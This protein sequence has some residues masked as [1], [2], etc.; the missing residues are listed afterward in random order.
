MIDLNSTQGQVDD[1]LAHIRERVATQSPAETLRLHVPCSGR[2]AVA[3]A[4]A[5]HLDE[6][7]AAG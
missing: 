7:S 2:A 5:T 3:L 4:V 1:L 6:V